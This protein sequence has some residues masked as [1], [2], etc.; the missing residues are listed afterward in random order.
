MMIEEQLKDILEKTFT[1]QNL[2]IVNESRHHIG[3][4]NSPETGESHFSVTI[5]SDD[6]KNM[7]RIQ[8][9]QQ[10]N[11]CVH[12]LFDEGLHALSL[13]LFTPSEERYF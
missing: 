5:V 13:S 7:S 3:H 12:H 1:C 2:M 6:F 11:E 8:R 9:H 4:T 10:V